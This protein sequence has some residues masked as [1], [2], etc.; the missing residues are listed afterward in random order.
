MSDTE[1]NYVILGRDGPY[2]VRKW[3][4]EYWMFWWHVDGFWVSLRAMI[5]LEVEIRYHQA[6]PEE[7]A[8]LYHRKHHEYWAAR[9]TAV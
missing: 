4:G 8:Q 1:R 2:W 5:L 3:E 9:E 7:K 6:I